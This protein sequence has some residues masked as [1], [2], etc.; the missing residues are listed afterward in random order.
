MHQVAASHLVAASAQVAVLHQAAA[1]RMWPHHTNPGSTR[2][3]SE[4]LCCDRKDLQKKGSPQKKRSVLGPL[5]PMESESFF[6]CQI[7]DAA[8]CVCIHACARVRACVYVCVCV[9]ACACVRACACAC[10]CLCAYMH[11]YARRVRECVCLCAC[12]YRHIDR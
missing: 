1:L 11:A 12:V 6:R 4:M 5:V 7:T 8:V 10:A 9:H 3:R 2:A